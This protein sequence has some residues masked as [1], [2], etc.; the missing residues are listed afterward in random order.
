MSVRSLNVILIL[1]VSTLMEVIY[2]SAIQVRYSNRKQTN[3][4]E[5]NL[6]R[7]LCIRD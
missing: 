7:Q 5:V 1:F 3:L 6:I 2:V 4:I